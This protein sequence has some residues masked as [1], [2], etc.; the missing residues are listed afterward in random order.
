MAKAEH[1]AAEEDCTDEDCIAYINQV[2][3]T[4]APQIYTQFLDIMKEFKAQSIDTPGVIERVLQLF[5]GHRMLILGFNTFLPP[6][7]KI[8]FTTDEDTPRVQLKY[9]PG[10]TGP[11]PQPYIPPSQTPQQRPPPSMPGMAPAPYGGQP[12]PS[13][14]PEIQSGAPPMAPMGGGAPD[15]ICLLYTSPSPRD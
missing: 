11:Q 8:E 13:G 5:N 6:G 2:K 15:W 4:V 1:E 7:Y 10:M 3:R 9:P 14:P 12:L